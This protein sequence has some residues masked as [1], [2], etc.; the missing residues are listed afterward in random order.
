MKTLEIRR[1]SFRKSGGGSQLSQEGVDYARRLG[2]SLGPFAQVV[3]SVVPRARE[4][5][6]AMGFAVDYEVVTLVS[7]EAVFAEIERSRWWEAAQPFTALAQLMATKG[8]TWRYGHAL[9]AQWRDLLTSIPEGAAALMIGHS[10]ELEIG[11]VACFLH[12]DHGSWGAPF[13]IC[14]GARLVFAGEPEH[15]TTVEFLR[16]EPQ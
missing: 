9:T 7:E 2:A 10:G 11:L 4:T 14:E 16:S 13:G 5:A 6:I 3:T 8:A 1:H 12:A 15:F